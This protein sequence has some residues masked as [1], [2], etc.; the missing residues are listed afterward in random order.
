VNHI[1]KWTCKVTRARSS[2]LRRGRDRSPADRAI[3]VSWA[4]RINRIHGNSTFRLAGPLFDVIRNGMSSGARTTCSSKHQR[5]F[6]GTN[7][8]RNVDRSCPAIWCPLRDARLERIGEGMWIGATR[9]V[10]SIPEPDMH[11]RNESEKECGSELDLDFLLQGSR[12][13]GR[14]ESEKECGLERRVGQI[15]CRSEV[16]SKGMSSGVAGGSPVKPELECGSE[17]QVPVA[18]PS[19]I[20]IKRNVEWSCGFAACL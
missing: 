10:S 20:E 14:N 13:H 16:K 19:T 3:A 18:W 9:A 2:A 8:R 7:R 15:V 5:L 1:E 11:G 6:V 4:A 17:P 12:S